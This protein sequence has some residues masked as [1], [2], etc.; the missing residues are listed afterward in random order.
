MSEE[1]K[2]KQQK[3]IDRLMDD[4]IIF[5]R[6]NGIAEMINAD[7]DFT[8]LR[9]MV[10]RI[11]D[12][13]ENQLLE[14]SNANGGTLGK[15]NK[16]DTDHRMNLYKKKVDRQKSG[17]QYYRI[18][19]EGDSWFQF[20]RFLKDIIDWLNDNDDFLIASEAYG[21][22]W[23]TNIVYEE[24]YVQ[25]LSTY[26]PDFFLISGGGNDLVGNH[27][28]G[29]MVD[30]TAKIASKKY[31][32]I[33]QI[34]STILSEKE[35]QMI[36]KAQDHLNKEFYAL[37]A[38][39]QLQYTVLFNKIYADDCKHKNVV[40]I[41]QGYDYPIPSPKRRISLRTPLQPVINSFLDTG[42]WL[43][44]PLMIKGILDEH[45][46]RS[47]MFTMIFEFNEMLSSFTKIQKYKVFHVDNRGLT[48]SHDDWYD[49]LHLKK[50][51]YKRVAK[52]YEYIIRNHRS[53]D[54]RRIIRTKDL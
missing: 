19:A 40:T 17:K 2:E 1:L 13:N 54:N 29:V 21:G 42:N 46:Q 18:Y 10:C 24:Q 34:N 48:T 31:S 20:P 5:V 25:G 37:L 35:K 12:L 53:L 23:I 43:F 14:M 26:P 44:T 8:H 4:P 36:I 9:S 51:L 41:T 27:R 45:A 38:V 15:M 49:E 11:Y 7:F 22:D 3:L 6:E 28:L 47:I 32:S 52:S 39:F 50:H 33:D 30:K 16:K